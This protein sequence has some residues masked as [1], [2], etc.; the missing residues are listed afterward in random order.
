MLIKPG[1]GPDVSPHPADVSGKE[2]SM[3]RFSAG[4]AAFAVFLSCAA[5]DAQTKPEGKPK[6]E[7]GEFGGGVKLAGVLRDREFDQVFNRSGAPQGKDEFYLDAVVTLNLNIRISNTANLFVQMETIDDAFAGESHRI[8]DNM[9]IATFQQGWLKVEEIFG[10]DFDISLKVG[11]MDVKFDTRNLG[12][13]VFLLDTR[14]ENPFT[15]LPCLVGRANGTASNQGHASGMVQA[16]YNFS[17]NK[18][19]GGNAWIHNFSGQSKESEA[20][21]AVITWKMGQDVILDFGAV[22]VMEGGMAYKDTNVMFLNLDFQ[23]D[24]GTQEKGLKKEESYDDR[25]LINVIAVAFLGEHSL[26]ADVGLGFD[27]LLDIGR[28][29]EI[30]LFGEAHYQYGGKYFVQ[31][32]ATPTGM[33][34]ALIRHEA[35]GCYGGLR[36]KVTDDSKIHPYFE[37]SYWRLSGDRGDVMEENG[38][39]MSMENVDSTIILEGNEVGYDIDCN[40][41]AIK[42]EM[43]FHLPS[44]LNCISLRIS[45]GAFW[46]ISVPKDVMD[47]NTNGVGEYWTYSQT[48]TGESKRNLGWEIDVKLNWDVTEEA[49]IFISVAALRDSAFLRNV[50]ELHGTG[51][52]RSYTHAVLAGIEMKF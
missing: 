16:A 50:A 27:L 28:S 29:A 8:G 35:Y 44:S 2:E 9:Q 10:Q 18:S 34:R 15:G 17:R 51:S 45:G 4:L 32:Y 24:I 41:W 20:G 33:D 37:V 12:R 39:F 5:A 48:F 42:G 43:G 14:S 26:V 46:L 6:S 23:F 19:F 52:P 40:Y 49:K 25:S 30:E 22:T 7:I 1:I 13:D 11:L 47:V 38:D 21:G 31:N 36:F 3:S